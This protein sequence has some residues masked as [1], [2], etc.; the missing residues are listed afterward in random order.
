MPTVP[1]TGHAYARARELCH[2]M[3]DTTRLFT[4]LV[5]LRE[6]H[7]NR[8]E[9]HIARELAEACLP[10]ARHQHAPALLGTAALLAPGIRPATQ[11]QYAA[12]AT[13][14]QRH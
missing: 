2:Q 9:I 13:A 7:L 1:E 8:E 5:G 4:V 11:A 6:F 3:G 12:P 10:L 14:L